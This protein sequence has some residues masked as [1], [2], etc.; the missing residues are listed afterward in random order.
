MKIRGLLVSA[1]VFAA[2]AGVLYWSDHRKPSA[3]VAKPDSEAAQSILKL[4]ESSIA[5]LE[6]KKRDAAPIVLA[7]SGT[8]WNIAEPKPLGADQ[9]TEIGM[10][11]TI[12]SLNS[13]R[14]VEDK[15]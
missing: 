13:D 2:L 8:D 7:K 9:S 12:S 15:G 14:L 11:S 1:I 5:K 10:L 4:D 3:E 6:L